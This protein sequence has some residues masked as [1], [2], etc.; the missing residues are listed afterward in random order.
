MVAG[1]LQSICGFFFSMFLESFVLGCRSLNKQVNA[2]VPLFFHESGT[3]TWHHSLLYKPNF[4]GISQFTRILRI[5]RTIP[6][7]RDCDPLP[8]SVSQALIR[9]IVL[10]GILLCEISI[11]VY[12]L[13]ATTGGGQNANFHTTSLPPLVALRDNETVSKHQNRPLVPLIEI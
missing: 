7:P 10:V 2:M 13:K 3:W 4:E 1:C 6:P 9:T 5:G 8:G 12:C 11:L